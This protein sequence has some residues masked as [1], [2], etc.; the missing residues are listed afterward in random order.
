MRRLGQFGILSTLVN[1]V[2]TINIIHN[3]KKA[4]V[5]LLPPARFRDGEFLHDKPERVAELIDPATTRLIMGATALAFQPFIDYRNRGVDEE[6]RRVSV[7]RTVAKILVC[8]A[9]GF[10][11]RKGCISLVKKFSQ[12][13]TQAFYPNA[14]HNIDVKDK[15]ILTKLKSINYVNTMGTCVA[16]GVMLF[17]NFLIDAPLTK[18]FTN[19][20]VK[21]TKPQQGSSMMHFRTEA[22]DRFLS[23]NTK[24]GGVNEPA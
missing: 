6:T 16:L 2:M 24:A 21:K 1:C 20:L 3:A 23:A 17:T 12:K 7:A 10:A 15:D 19:L 11:I 9:T 8:T 13:P 22:R 4:V 14:G 18:F 5:N